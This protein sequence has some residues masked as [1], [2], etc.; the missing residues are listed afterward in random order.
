ME[1]VVAGGDQQDDPLGLEPPGREG[2][3][4]GR[5]LVQP[6]GVVDQADQRPLLG[7]LGEQ[8]QRAHTDQEAVGALGG[9]EPEGAP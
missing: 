2:E 4:V 7:H 9:G 6:L 5:R 1:V 3:G 8:A